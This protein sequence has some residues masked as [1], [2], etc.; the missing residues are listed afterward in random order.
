MRISFVEG[1]G[2]N[3]AYVTSLKD[4]SGQLVD[5]FMESDGEDQAVVIID[6]ALDASPLFSVRY[7]RERKCI[8][9][10]IGYP[11]TDIDTSSIKRQIAEVNKG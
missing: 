7:D 2:E 4:L 3:M 6:G 5:A 9:I 1:Q 11:D 10:Q 8:A